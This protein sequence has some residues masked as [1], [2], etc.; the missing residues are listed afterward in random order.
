MNAQK[1]D[2]YGS[3]LVVIDANTKQPMSGALVMFPE[4]DRAAYQ[5]MKSYV[6]ER[7]MADD[8]KFMDWFRAIESLWSDAGDAKGWDTE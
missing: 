1:S 4:V 6:S 7:N 8:T 3:P 5:A 2:G